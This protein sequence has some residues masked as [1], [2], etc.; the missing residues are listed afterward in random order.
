MRFNGIGTWGQSKE[1]RSFREAEIESLLQFGIGIVE[2]LQ[3][4]GYMR[5]DLNSREVAET[6]R[7]QVGSVAALLIADADP[8]TQQRQLG[9]I[10]MTVAYLLQPPTR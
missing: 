10:Q 4:K 2:D 7:D 6:L 8:C 3:A 1:F 9:L 5:K